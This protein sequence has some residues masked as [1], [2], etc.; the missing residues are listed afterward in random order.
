MTEERFKYNPYEAI[1]NK[2]FKTFEKDQKKTVYL[3]DSN[4]GQVMVDKEN[5]PIR[6]DRYEGKKSS[7]IDDQI[8]IKIFG[9]SLKNLVALSEPGFKVMLYVMMNIRPK[10]E[11]VEILPALAVKKLNYKTT[12][13]VYDGISNLIENDVIARSEFSNLYWINPTIFYNGS[14]RHL[15]KEKY[16]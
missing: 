1:V 12:K 4:T 10:T 3:M 2:H 11:R 9:S 6:M 14:R 16:H 15:F 7:I 13:S 5:K 8:Y